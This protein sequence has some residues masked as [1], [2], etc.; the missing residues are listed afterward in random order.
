MQSI[1]RRY[2]IYVRRIVCQ[3]GFPSQ[4]SSEQS[5]ILTADGVI[6]LTPVITDDK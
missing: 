5:V 4:F 1:K 6:S 2:I 3:R